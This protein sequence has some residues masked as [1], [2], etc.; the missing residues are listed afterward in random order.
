[1]L[2]HFC[3]AHIYNFITLHK[4]QGHQLESLILTPQPKC[5]E[6]V[7]QSSEDEEEDRE[8]GDR[9]EVSVSVKDLMNPPRGNMQTVRRARLEGITGTPDERC[10]DG[11]QCLRRVSPDERCQD[12]LQRLCRVNP[13]PLTPTSA[14]W[15]DVCHLSDCPAN[16]SQPHF[17]S[18]D[19]RWLSLLRMVHGQCTQPNLAVYLLTCHDWSH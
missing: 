2:V 6:L 14:T 17:W 16:T 19:L 5:F 13:P 4:W 11:L 1:M 8:E 10:Q 12:S 15:Q 3:S 18:S 9:S 7:L